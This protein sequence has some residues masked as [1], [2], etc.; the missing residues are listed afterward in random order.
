MSSKIPNDLA[1]PAQFNYTRPANIAF[2]ANVE[3]CFKK[4][5]K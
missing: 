2:K 5:N 1:F 3:M 4:N